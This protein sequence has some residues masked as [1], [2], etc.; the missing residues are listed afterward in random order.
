MKPRLRGV[1]SSR[2][3]PT[4]RRGRRELTAL[5]VCLSTILL[6]SACVRS[7]A[8]S[9]TATTA[10]RSPAAQSST[11]A[12]SG[13]PT[14]SASSSTTSSSSS[15]TASS[16]SSS[17]SS[18]TRPGPSQAQL[19]A[20][21]TKA[22]RA[23]PAMSIDV[24]ELYGAH[25]SASYTPNR[26]YHTAS[27]YKL[28]VAYALIKRIEAGTYTWQSL[29]DGIPAD[30]CMYRML[31]VS[32]N[33]CGEAFA[34]TI[35][36]PAIKRDLQAIGLQH[37]TFPGGLPHSTVGDQARFLTLLAHGTLMNKADAAR[38]TGLMKHQ[39]YRL[40]IPAGVPY[41]V[42]DKVGFLWQLLHDSA[43]VYSP[44]GTY[45]LSIY[46]DR[47]TWNDIAV[48]ARGINAV[49]AK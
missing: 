28:Y 4:R 39:V 48:A 14:A 21:V 8:G 30:T 16:S 35:G 41:P 3:L 22:A 33:E 12:P 25:R 17:S 18:S 42:A 2:E 44:H 20:A 38:L 31:Y 26:L 5:V 46:S 37:T 49:L 15:T 29:F 47:G 36:W 23:N 24:V 45:V 13:T 34:F 6:L 43:I 7:G 40:G 9:G 10:L 1:G 11:P 19:Q 32:D 27:T